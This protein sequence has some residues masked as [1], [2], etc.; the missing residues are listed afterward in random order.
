MYNIR[1]VTLPNKDTFTSVFLNGYLVLDDRLLETLANKIKPQSFEHLLFKTSY[2]YIDNRT[3]RTLLI[4]LLYNSI[5]DDDLFDNLQDMYQISTL[6][7]I[8]YVY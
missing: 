8:Y 3:L 6:I 2:I 1:Q 4:G 5:N 7:F